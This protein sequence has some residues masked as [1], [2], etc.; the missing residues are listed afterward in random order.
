MLCRDEK[1]AREMLTLLNKEFSRGAG[2][3]AQRTA[4]R[5]NEATN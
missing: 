5:T 1:E 2:G 3:P 4:A